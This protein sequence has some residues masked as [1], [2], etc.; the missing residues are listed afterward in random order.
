[1]STPA[2]LAALRAGRDAVAAGSPAYFRALP[3]T[4]GETY[5][6][7]SRLLSRALYEESRGDLVRPRDVPQE[8]RL[9]AYDLAIA[10]AGGEVIA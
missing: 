8:T 4:D 1:M 7:A 3:D 10:T 5:E 6:A 9:A 2:V